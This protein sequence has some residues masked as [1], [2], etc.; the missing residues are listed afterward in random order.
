MQVRGANNNPRLLLPAKPKHAMI[1]K[2]N[3]LQLLAKHFHRTF[4]SY[5]IYI[6]T[7]LSEPKVSENKWLAAWRLVC[8]EMCRSHSPLCQFCLLCPQLQLVQHVHG[9][10]QRS[11][12][13]GRKH[14]SKIVQTR[15]NT[16]NHID[17][18]FPKSEAS[19]AMPICNRSSSKDG[20]PGCRII[21]CWKD[22]ASSHDISTGH[23]STFSEAASLSTF[24]C[25]IIANITRQTSST[26]HALFSF[27]IPISVA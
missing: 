24:S 7:F 2:L 25:V 5:L 26:W 23:A 14:P 10:G 9:A 17:M 18:H 21:F 15:H 8:F 16:Q 1:R 27:C 20:R 12:L 4:P 22:R 6:L 11:I 3:T 13:G 19:A